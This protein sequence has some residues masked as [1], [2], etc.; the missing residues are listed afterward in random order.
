MKWTAYCTTCKHEL[1]TAPNGGFVEATARRHKNGGDVYTNKD[2]L[3]TR[4]NSDCK[5]ISS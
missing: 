2:I 3:I 4:G 1:D 5:I